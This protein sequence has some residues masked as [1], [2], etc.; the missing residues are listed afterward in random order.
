MIGQLVGH[1]KVIRKIGDGGMGSVFEAEHETIG[2]HVAIKILR[3]EYS[4]DAKLVQRFFNEARAVNIVTHPGIVG[5]FDYGQL[6]NGTA[7]IVMEFVEG[8]S[9][10][11]R[12]KR[13]GLLGMDA[14]RIV[15]Q[16]AATLAAAHAKGIIHRGRNPGDFS[17]RN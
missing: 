5:S 4:K 9:L 3:S 12:L 15:R 16:I 1:Y 7:Y 13:R 10:S 11:A 8:E 2:R 14:L 17:T 6:E